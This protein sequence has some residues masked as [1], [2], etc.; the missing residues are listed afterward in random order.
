MS[1]SDTLEDLDYIRALAEEGRSA[2][3]LGGGHLA[4]YGALTTIA[5][6]A[7]WAV[8]TTK[9]PDVFFAIVWGGYGVS[10]AIAGALMRRRIEGKPGGGALGNRVE[11]AVWLA[12][13]VAIGAVWAGAAAR[14]V[15]QNNGLEMDLLTPTVFAAYAT[16]LLTTGRIVND[17]VLIVAAVLAYV[18]AAIAVTLI[19][20]PTL[21]LVTAAGAAA[22]LLAPGLILMRREPSEVV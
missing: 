16:G 4:A 6:L 18:V 5:Y 22:T 19:H 17:R 11:R 14:S 7:H 15:M 12:A 13:G 2:P 10:M 3:L 8:L 9:A 21:Y 20:T 1:R